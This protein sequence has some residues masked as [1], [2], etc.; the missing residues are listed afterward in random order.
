MAFDAIVFNQNELEEAISD[1]CVSIVLCDG[2]FVLPPLPDITYTI[3]GNA[4]TNT[5]TKNTE[6]VTSYQTSYQTSYRTSYATSYQTSY[7]TSYETSYQT[8]YTTSYASSYTA[9]F[10]GSYVLP[11]DKPQCECIMVNGYGINLI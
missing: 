7:R 5:N 10:S 9:S 6:Y 3:I 4:R 8:S 11:Q 1:G 2:D